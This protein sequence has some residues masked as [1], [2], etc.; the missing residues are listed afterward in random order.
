M[1][2]FIYIVKLQTGLYILKKPNDVPQFVKA[3]KIYSGDQ[4]YYQIKYIMKY[5]PDAIIYRTER[6]KK[7]A[8]NYTYS[9]AKEDYERL[10]PE[11][12]RQLNINFK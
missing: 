3:L 10:R 7:L 6:L 8:A 11:Q 4:L 5:R 12:G 9:D 1:R 2:S